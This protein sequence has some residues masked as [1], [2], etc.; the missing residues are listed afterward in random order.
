MSA[1]VAFTIDGKTVQGEQGQ[2]ILQAAALASI[3]IPHLCA[4]KGLSPWGSCR[5]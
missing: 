4:M 3:Y 5:V 1:K 2:T